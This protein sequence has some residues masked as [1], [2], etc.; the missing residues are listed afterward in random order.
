[1]NTALTVSNALETMGLPVA[2]RLPG[3]TGKGRGN[4]ALRIRHHPQR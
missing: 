3:V 1:M 4:C 2:L